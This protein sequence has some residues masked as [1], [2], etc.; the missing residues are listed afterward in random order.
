MNLSKFSLDGKVAIIV[1]GSRGIGRAIAIAF[2][3]AGADVAISSRKLPELEIVA[4]EITKRG[5][6]SIAIPAH[7]AKKED[8][9]RLY[10]TVMER[11]GKID[12]LVNGAAANPAYGPILDLKEEI[13]DVIMN[14]NLK[15]VFLLSQKVA[16][17]MRDQKGGNIINISSFDGIRPDQGLGCY[18]ISKAGLIMLTKVMAQELAQYNIR[19]NA[20]AP[21]LVKTRFSAALW[22]NQELLEGYMRSIPLKRAAEPEEV[23]GAAMYLASEASSYVTGEVMVVSGG[24]SI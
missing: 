7:A 3:D 8:L 24:V 16:N 18:C 23:V 5:R 12:I 20:I 1:G 2:A 4:G 6:K 22:S 17:I 13:W 21:G 9:D 15:G 11:F 10:Q 14:L 19:V